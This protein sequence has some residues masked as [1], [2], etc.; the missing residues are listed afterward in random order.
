[1]LDICERCHAQFLSSPGHINT[2]FWSRLWYQPQQLLQDTS[3]RIDLSV[4]RVGVWVGFFDDI[5]QLRDLMHEG[6]KRERCVR[7]FSPLCFDH[8]VS[9]YVHGNHAN[10]AAVL[11]EYVARTDCQSCHSRL[12]PLSG[13]SV[14]CASTLESVCG[15]SGSLS[16]GACQSCF[17]S[18]NAVNFGTC[19][20]DDTLAWCDHPDAC[21]GSE[22]RPVCALHSVFQSPDHQRSEVRVLLQLH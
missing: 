2:L 16:T 4:R 18:I 6:Q 7:L 22:E 19:S 17:S 20:S 14:D 5:A 1:M 13:V 11:K 10:D 21:S 12:V 3:I 15:K 9:G 8:L